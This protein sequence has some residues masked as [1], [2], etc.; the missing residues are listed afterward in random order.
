MGGLILLTHSHNQNDLKIDFLTQSTHVA[1]GLIGVMVG[2]ARWLELR[3]VPPY[4]R[5]A[6]LFAVSG[7]MLVGF[8]LLF[9]MNPE[10]SSI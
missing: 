6:G 2:C 8:I 4:D 10:L 9:Y 7:I 1:M 5:V 3:L